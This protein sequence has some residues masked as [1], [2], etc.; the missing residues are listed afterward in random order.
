[1]VREDEPK[2][3]QIYKT[4]NPWNGGKDGLPSFIFPVWFSYVKYF[5]APRDVVARMAEVEQF[6]S[7]A[8]RCVDAYHHA[9]KS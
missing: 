4:S 7:V 8:L 2:S 1:V 3:L 5:P 6:A 9:L